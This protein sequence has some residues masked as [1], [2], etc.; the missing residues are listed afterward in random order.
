MR[1]LFI[2]KV[3]SIGIFSKEDGNTNNDGSEK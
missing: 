3:V 1:D 2:H